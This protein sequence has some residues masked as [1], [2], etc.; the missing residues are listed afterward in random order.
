MA[1][2]EIFIPDELLPMA[3]DLTRFW[4]AMVYKLR[5]NAHKGKWE[6]LDLD[7]TMGRLENEVS[8]LDLAIAEKSFCEILLEGADVANFAMIATSVALSEVGRPTTSVLHVV[9]RTPPTPPSDGSPPAATPSAAT[10]AAS[11]TSAPPTTP[12][13]QRPANFKDVMDEMFSRG[14]LVARK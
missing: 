4:S 3:Q 5:K 7:Q 13:S 6:D 14:P 8:E 10:L 11:A 9:S 2:V 12:P 1:T